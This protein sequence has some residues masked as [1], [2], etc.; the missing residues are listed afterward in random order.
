MKQI[1]SLQIAK[2]AKE[3]GFMLMCHFYYTSGELRESLTAHA[4][5]GHLNSYIGDNYSAP[6]RIELQRW[7]IDEYGIEALEDRLLDGLKLINQ[8]KQ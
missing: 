2:L 4:D 6:T 5:S 7:L 1:I 8:L 3:K